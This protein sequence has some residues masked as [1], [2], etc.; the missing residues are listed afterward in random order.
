MRTSP[1]VSLAA[2]GVLAL[3][4]L[5]ACD[6][7]QHQENTRAFEPSKFF[8]DGSSARTPPA[9][10]VSRAAAGPDDSS[11]TGV[12]GGQWLRGFPMM[13]DR[14]FVVRGGE[15]YAIADARIERC[16]RH[17]GELQKPSGEGVL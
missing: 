6:N 13:L 9:H 10:T 15:R 8:A 12:R 1:K 11:S 5:A 14:D 2:A 16:P 7:M 17:L 3:L 4:G